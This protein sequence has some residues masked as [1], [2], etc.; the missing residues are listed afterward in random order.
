MQR[1]EKA[2]IATHLVRAA[3]NGARH[4]HLLRHR[5]D[6]PETIKGYVHRPITC[7]AVYTALAPNRFKD[8][9]RD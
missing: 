9:W 2:E 7:T 3:F 4:P 1:L 8:F 5:A 6:C